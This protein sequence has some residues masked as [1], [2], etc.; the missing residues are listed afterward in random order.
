MEFIPANIDIIVNLVVRDGKPAMFR[1][2]KKLI[3]W[4]DFTTIFVC[5][6]VR[7]R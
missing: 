6:S 3:I 4:Q 2:Y 5:I 7:L 1:F